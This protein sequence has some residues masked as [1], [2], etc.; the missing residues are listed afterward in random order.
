GSWLWV[1]DRGC[2]IE[3]RTDGSPAITAGVLTDISARRRERL[4]IESERSRL[5]AL[6][7]TLPDMVWLKDANGVYLECNPL[8]ARLFGL[9]PE[10]IIGRHDHD[11]LPAEVADTLRRHDQ[12]TAERGETQ[13]IEETLRFPDGHEERLETLKTPVYTND[14]H[15]LG[16]L[17]IAHDITERESNR[18]RIAA[19]NRAL[20]LMNGIAQALVRHADEAAMLDEICH[21]LVDVGGYRMSWIA[22]ANDDAERSIEPL[23]EAGFVAGYLADLELSWAAGPAG[24]GPTG[25]AIRDGVP[26]I[27]Q[28]IA[29]DPRFAPWRAKAVELGYRSSIALPL[30]ID[31]RVIG[32][33]NLYASAANAFTDEELAL[34]TNLGDELGLGMA[35]Q[36]SRQALLSSE[37][38]LR[39]AQ[40]LA[41]LGHYDFD[42]LADH[43]N[44]SPELAAIFGIADD[45][46]HTAAGWLALIHPEDRERMARHLHDEVLGRMRP[47]DQQY[48]IMRHHDGAVVWVHG[49]GELQ[50]DAQ[51]VVTRMFGT[52]QDISSYVRLEQELLKNEASLRDAQAIAHMGSWTLDI[53]SG[54]LD[55][56]DE[57][58]RIFG[59]QRGAPQTLSRFT[60]SIHPDDR[61]RVLAA[62]EAALHGAVYD[63]THRIL[64]DGQVRWVRERAQIRVSAAGEAI[65]AVGSVQDITEQRNVEDSLRKLSLAIEQT[66][67]NVIVTNTRQEIEYVNEAFVRNTGYTRAE[68]IGRTPS[69]LQSGQTPKATYAALHAALDRGEV[70]R[71][72]FVNRRRDGSLFEAFAIISPVRQPDGRVTHF[73][74]IE[75]DISEKKRIQAE[76]DRHRQHLETLVTE[77]TIQLRQASEQAEA[78]SRAKSAFLANMSHEIRTPMNAIVGLTHLA[79]RDPGLTPALS[80]RLTKVDMATRH[81]L[82]IINDILDI[83]KI[84]AGKLLLE[85]SDFSVDRLVAS[86]R[87]LVAERAAAKELP[88]ICQIDPALPARLRGDPLRIQQILVNFLS[89]AVKFTERGSIVIALRLLAS[90]NG[91]YHVRFEVRDSGIGI[92][93]D[94]QARLFTPFEQADTSTTRRYGGTGL[95]LAI[96]A[97]LAHAMGGDIDVDSQPGKGATFWFSARLGAA[98]DNETAL[99]AGTANPPASFSASTRILLAEDNPINEE[100]ASAL[101]QSAG[102]SVDVAGDG[103]A[104]VA[105]AERQVY[106]LVLMDMQMPVMDG[107]TAT[108][109]IRRLPGWAGVPILAMTANAFAE[110]RNACLAAG[111]NDHVAKPVNP[112]HL[113]ATLARWLPQAIPAAPTLPT[114]VLD[115]QAFAASLATVSGLN[116]DLG[117]HAVRGRVASYRRL[118]GRFIDS[119]GDDTAAIRQC[120]L[121]GEREE[122]RRLAHS[123]KGA[124]ATL[125]ATAVQA[126]AAASEAAIRAEAGLATV[127]PLLDELAT[128]YDDLGKCL[129]PL[130][131]APETAPCSAAPPPAPGAFDEL[132]RLL[133]EGEVHVQELLHLQEPLLRSALGSA[134][135][136]FARLIENFDF[137]AARVLLDASFPPGTP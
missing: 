20:R 111:M 2:I 56:S 1:E 37:S 66:P 24:N 91:S 100:V 90:D 36:R 121:K 57:V 34:L 31:G 4:Q 51:G 131:A 119:H 134:Y 133:E 126:A 73:L 44:C 25:C 29:H 99:P 17:G 11:L 84:E 88:L 70:W 60:D 39:Q 26:S 105:L 129:R 22:Q 50:I 15:L 35:M 59:Q 115:D 38:S 32:S 76:L 40:H 3:H 118:L 10:A 63:C 80:K 127:E 113:F 114:T 53:V 21:L 136:A 23:A 64:V 69:L 85:D 135:P 96:S 81:L 54:A 112:D 120:L 87:D 75:E 106:D 74:S 101:L 104:A 67:H 103:A 33:F 107:L 79:L 14:G 124:A 8:A 65:S 62:W 71:G 95:G 132:R 13:R 52:I 92:P 72:E 93:P 77:R 5:S 28:D 108:R 110:D 58:Y 82:S 18:E 98:H 117:L 6:L 7:R 41:S 78:A 30:R 123:L 61:E 48:R 116:A 16:V 9:P 89:N 46:P 19:Q 27:V 83:S 130:L 47:F 137:E 109:R 68:A 86:A 125:G 122:A 128:L 49:T 102:L 94:I 12:L 55:W 42:P 97:R 43:W 45:Y